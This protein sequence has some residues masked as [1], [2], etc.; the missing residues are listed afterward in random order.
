[1]HS[2]H[3]LKLKNAYYNKAV[4]LKLTMADIV[5][6]VELCCLFSKCNKFLCTAIFYDLYRVGIFI[7]NYFRYWKLFSELGNGMKFL[8]IPKV[9][10]FF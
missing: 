7:D 3:Y 4:A 9:E 6:P 1:M 2:K 5:K 8:V 10:L